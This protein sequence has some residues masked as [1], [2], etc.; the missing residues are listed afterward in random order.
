MAEKSNNVV[1]FH[2]DVDGGVALLRSP[3]A[4][5]SR[6]RRIQMERDHLRLQIKTV[7]HMGEIYNFLSRDWTIPTEEERAK[8]AAHDIYVSPSVR[9]KE[10]SKKLDYHF[11]MLNKVVPDLSAHQV[12]AQVETTSHSSVPTVKI[13]AFKDPQQ[14]L[15][16]PAQSTR[17]RTKIKGG[18]A[19]GMQEGKEGEAESEAPKTILADYNPVIRVIQPQGGR[20][21]EADQKVLSAGQQEDLEWLR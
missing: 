5:T 16:A 9:I 3:E 2:P 17:T 13:V 20:E 6:A 14:M 15:P 21:V 4:R 11:K 1:P 10:I 18:T 8:E 19:N 7:Y 12:D